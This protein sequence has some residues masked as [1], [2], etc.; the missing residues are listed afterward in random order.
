M[1]AAWLCGVTIK[2]RPKNRPEVRGQAQIQEREAK[3]H[4]VR[5]GD[6]PDGKEGENKSDQRGDGWQSRCEYGKYNGMRA[7]NKA[8]TGVAMVICPPARAR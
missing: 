8:E 1:Y 2:Y 4:P 5:L 6:Q 3:V 7:E